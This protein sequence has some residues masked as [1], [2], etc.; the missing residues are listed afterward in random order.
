MV[1]GFFC[2]TMG[3]L[4][5]TDYLALSE[6][7]LRL[8]RFW[9]GG[10]GFRSAWVIL[11]L[12][13]CKGVV[14]D[15]GDAAHPESHGPAANPPREVRAADAAEVV[16]RVGHTHVMPPFLIM[17]ALAAQA[18]VTAAALQTHVAGLG[19]L[20]GGFRRVAQSP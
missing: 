17:A 19:R 3:L 20:A 15:D 10:G 18:A 7:R 12:E 9:G 5:W 14:G 4:L 1:N 6:P 16:V 13:T 8:V 11:A 2:L